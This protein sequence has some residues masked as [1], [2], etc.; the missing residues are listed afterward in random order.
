VR[1]AQIET[2]VFRETSR[3]LPSLYNTLRNSVE[4]RPRAAARPPEH[5][6]VGRATL[7]G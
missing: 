3:N 4:A 5:S 1:G 2:E 7:R 6:L